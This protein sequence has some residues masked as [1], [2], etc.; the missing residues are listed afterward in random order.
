MG[1]KVHPISFRLGILEP[2]RSRWY[3]RKRDFGR[4][5]VED[6]QIRKIVKNNYRF[7][8]IARIDI[9]RTREEVTVALHTARPGIIIGRKGVE[10]DRLRVRLE[11]LSNKK[12][13]I[14]IIE[15]SKPE[16]NGQMVAESIAEQLSKR[17][18]FRRTM[19]R[20]A[21][22]TMDGGAEGVRIQ[23]SGRLGGAEMS[24]REHTSIGKIPL[25][26]LRAKIE[27][28]FTEART[29][30]GSIGVNV[31]IYL[32]EVDPATAGKEMSNAADAKT[33]QVP[34]GPPRQN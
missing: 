21:E 8:G 12:V 3:A 1:Q 20:G 26:T 25:S 19:K 7:A 18:S 22:M 11:E 4:F 31:W 14:N 16:L 17:A 2:W 15:I 33:G 13:N 24:R 30:Y 23:I 10:V 34:Q 29:T 27:Y 32:G 6:F 5:L 9:E 28:G